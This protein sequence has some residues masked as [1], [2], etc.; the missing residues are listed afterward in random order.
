MVFRILPALIILSAI[1]VGTRFLEVAYETPLIISE[2]KA[3]DEAAAE[4][5]KEEPKKEEAASK[6]DAHADKPKDEAKK[7]EGEAK[8]DPHAEKPKDDGHGKS[9]GEKPKTADPNF[10]KSTVK[11][12][13][14]EQDKA[15]QFTDVEAEVLQS[16]A[17]RRAELEK[18]EQDISLKEASLGVVEKNIEAKLNQLKALQSDL[19]GIIAEYNSKEDEKIK[20]L[21]KIYESMKPAEAAKIFEQLQMSV[22]LDVA[23]NMKEAKLASILAKMDTYKAKELTVEIAERRRVKNN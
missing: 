23:D 2:I 22:L 7:E 11:D 19:T 10:L 13:E 21:V 15:P 12:K 20:S 14:V 4:K 3:S 5:P 1:M 9:E 17:K 16:L 6:E 18:R 8:E